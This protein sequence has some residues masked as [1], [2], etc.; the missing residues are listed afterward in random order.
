MVALDAAWELAASEPGKC[1]EPS[2]VDS[3]FEW[4]PA[5]VP[6]TV[7]DA[8]RDA[9]W[10]EDAIT[11]ARIDEH[12]WWF[13]TRFAS[14][15]L[16]DGEEAF[17]VLDGIATVA[18]VYL[19]G[20]L[21]LREDSMFVRSQI[22]VSAQLA[23]ENELVICCRALAPLLAESRR[24]RQ[25]WRQ[26]VVA[27]ATLRFYRTMLIGR[28]A[29]FAPGPPVIGPW[30]AVR[31][32]RRRRV[33][34]DAI[35]LRP[36][37]EDG[38]GLLAVAIELRPLAARAVETVEVLLSDGA[39]ELRAV[40]ECQQSATG[41]SARGEVQ[42][43]EVAR[44]WP[45]THG[46]PVLYSVQ[47][48]VSG[49]GTQV[50]IDAGR[51]GFRDLGGGEELEERGLQLRINGVAVF[52]RGAVWMALEAAGPAPSEADLRAT[53][54]LV[55]A[56]GMNM[57]RIPGTGAYESSLFHDL[58]DELGILVWQ[59][60]AFANLDY[61]E[62]DP[63]FI[64]A[65]ER[66][67]VGVLGDLG[68]RPGLAVLCGSSE[69]AQQV[70]MVGLDPELASGPLFGELLPRLVS[71][72]A[73]DA[74]YVPSAPWG[75]A[76]PFRPDRGIA[77]YFG[78][79]G[80]RRP[81]EDARRANVLFAAECL[82]IANVPDEEI[83]AAVAPDSSNLTVV[84]DARWKA[85]AP[86][87][88][89]APWDF[90]DVRDHYFRVLFGLEPD[91]LR[92]ADPERYLELS[93]AV[94]GEVMA[95]VFGEWR[96]AET[97][98]G[99]GIVL[100]LRDLRPGA[101][102]GIIDSAGE[103]K[104][105]YHHLRRM[106]SPRAV[107]STDDGQSGTVA[108]VA[109]DGPQELRANLRVALYRDLELAVG[110][111]RTPVALAPHTQAAFD[112]EGLLGRF[113]DISWAYRFGPPAQDVVAFSLEGERDGASEMISQAFRLPA[114]RPTTP[115]TAS[116]LGFDA[117][118]E[119]RE[120]GGAVI[121]IDSRR[122]AYGVRI[123]CPGFRAADN[124]FSI[125]PGGTRRVELARSGADGEIATVTLTALNLAERVVL[126]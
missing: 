41:V 2:G 95:E 15:Q 23:R 109:N 123:H 76:M 64:A 93:R 47:I 100:S 121:R 120:A 104:V 122:F 31:I 113:V 6:G 92:D 88:P 62:S 103:P 69:V 84:S 57:L 116:A 17:L 125:E 124:G 36:R 19:N 1:A 27:D 67:A 89:G 4:M 13:R 8:L 107:W 37:I 66:E 22:D 94:S 29:G 119:R 126:Q 60:F 106:L 65:V 71:D 90:H 9:G 105:V 30:R 24:P 91:E 79:G 108:H 26:R 99:G 115:E 117:A 32:E 33:A 86:R 7:A 87:D 112:V 83:V 39:S 78:V 102:W 50:A 48:L 54:D 96:R 118:L 81:L 45:H 61:P 5:R 53:L 70:A 38:T 68:G 101:G 40:L 59:D 85:A 111:V 51:V 43:P 34:V 82:A 12:D 14:T 35:E 114:G 75:G 77:S 3:S 56:A 42:V 11:E 110:E 28:A 52:V 80:Y 97:R 72:A 49:A 21:V 58:C 98:C 20:A 44:W 16:A 10:A 55:R 18:E 73:L 63:A 25:R 46:D 74:V